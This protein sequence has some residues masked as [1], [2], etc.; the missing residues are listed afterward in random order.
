MFRMEIIIFC[1]L[2]VHWFYVLNCL[3][4][5]E[6][7]DLVVLRVFNVLYIG[8]LLKVMVTLVA[9]LEPAHLRHALVCFNFFQ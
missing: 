9:F 3:V 7:A 5:S 4:L 2:A 8:E 1:N 6:F